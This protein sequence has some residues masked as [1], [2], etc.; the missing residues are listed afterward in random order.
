MSG[1]RINTHYY[2]DIDTSEL[3]PKHQEGQKGHVIITYSLPDNNTLVVSMLDLD[4]VAAAI[5]AKQLA[6]EIMYQEPPDPT[7]KPAPAPQG[8][9]VECAQIT[10]SSDNL[11]AFISASDPG[12]LFKSVMTFRRVP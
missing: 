9:K 6:G 11:I 5:Q 7:K 1:V 4:P 2:L 12:R 3:T 10:D 8:P